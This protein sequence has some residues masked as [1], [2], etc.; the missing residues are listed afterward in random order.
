MNKI[1]SVFIAANPA[2][3][4]QL[5]L[6][7]EIRAITEKIRASEHRDMINLISLWAVRPDD[8]LQA[9]NQHHPHIVHF[10]G[11][12]SVT[13]EIILVD[14]LGTPKP[15]TA[16]A[17]KTL[18]TTLKDNIRIVILNACYSRIQADAIVSVIDCA[19][20]M[21]DAIGDKAA[22]V[23]AASFYRAIGFGRSVQEAFDQGVAALLLEGIPAENTPKLVTRTGID[24]ASMFLIKNANSIQQD[25]AQS[26]A[27]PKRKFFVGH[28]YDKQQIDDLRDCIARAAEGTIWQPIYADEKVVSG[29][30]LF[31]KIAPLI[32]E[33]EF[34][35]FEISSQS[36]PNVFIELGI[37][38][39]QNKP[40]Y[41]LLQQGVIPPTDLGGRDLIVYGSYKEL[42]ENLRKKVFSKKL[43]ILE[44]KYLRHTYHINSISLYKDDILLASGSGDR[45]VIVWKVETGEV[46]A[47]LKHDKWVGSVQFA[48]QGIYLAT[49]EGY[50]TVKLWNIDTFTL[51]AKQGAHQGDC[52]TV[53]FSP[54]G[55]LL[56]SGGGDGKIHL[57]EMPSLSLT[58]TL[59]GHTAE[60][61]RVAFSPTGDKLVSC[62]EDGT[63]NLWSLADKSYERI[64]QIPNNLI[65]SVA[66]SPNGKMIATT[67]SEGVVRVWDT[68][69]YAWRWEK[70]KHEGPAV[71]LCFD[72]SNKRV[73]SGGYDRL[74]YIWDVETGEII[75]RISEHQDGVTCLTFSHNGKWLFSGSRDK[76]IC[77]WHI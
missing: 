30:I 29:H 53:A 58:F 71:G 60:V 21:D 28:V 10:S 65:R 49:S 77:R 50:G 51:V 18:F 47:V 4:T 73:V 70:K 72:P 14:N 74:I 64:L 15:V 38:L 42:E 34:S 76:S 48:P 45:N 63:C 11:H 56:A 44:H 36:R 27:T 39:Q 59:E 31:D 35:I 55:E 67:D 17:L 25:P 5:R 8:L 52:R 41:L 46:V 9:L 2:K 23:F 40:V 33:C 54:T 62:G 3:T 69:R 26:P 75:D 20:G 57:W 7:E 12:G 13:G 66:Y 61:R 16:Q 32:S 24:P 22:N 1:T 37:A 43:G 68:T 6:D 19:I